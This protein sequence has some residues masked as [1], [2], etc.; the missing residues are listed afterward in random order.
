M[1]WDF[2]LLIL[3]V[4]SGVDL[5]VPHPSDPAYYIVNWLISTLLYRNFHFPMRI[6]EV[7]PRLQCEK[8]LR[9]LF[10][11]IPLELWAYLILLHYLNPWPDLGGCPCPA[12]SYQHGL[13]SMYCSH[14]LARLRK[15]FELLLY[16]N[17]SW[18]VSWSVMAI[19]VVEF[20]SEGY[21]IRKICV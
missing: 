13:P 16:P 1:I 17:I 20:S 12:L 4:L 8:V 10:L 15:L 5:F 19:P 21:K 3:G 6:V 11:R 9:L 7:G 18:Y 14:F 2:S